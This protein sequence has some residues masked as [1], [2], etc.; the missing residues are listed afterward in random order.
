[1]NRNEEFRQ[2]LDDLDDNDNSEVKVIKLILKELSVV[3]D[4]LEK[5]EAAK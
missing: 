3:R 2:K 4:R 1:M 5:L